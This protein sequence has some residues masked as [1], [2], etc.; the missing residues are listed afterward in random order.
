MIRTRR[1]ANYKPE[2]YSWSSIVRG[3]VLVELFTWIFACFQRRIWPP[4]LAQKTRVLRFP[5]P[6]PG[7]TRIPTRNL[8]GLMTHDERCPN[9]DHFSCVF[10]CKWM[11]ISFDSGMEFF[12]LLHVFYKSNSTNL[13][14]R[15]LQPTIVKLVNVVV[16]NL[17]LFHSPKMAGQRNRLAR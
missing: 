8:C 17:N 16:E 5:Q 12:F 1:L 15:M 6:F 14:F 7:G 3:R 13:W 9:E 11:R 4:T 10:L 2:K